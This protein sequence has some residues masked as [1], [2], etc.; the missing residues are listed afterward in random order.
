MM[1][2]TKEYGTDLVFD[3]SLK[4]RPISKIGQCEFEFDIVDAQFL[5]N[6]SASGGVV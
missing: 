4:F 2:K 1:A 5:T 6:A 3:N